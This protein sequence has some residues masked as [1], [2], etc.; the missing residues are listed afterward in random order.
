ML[1]LEDKIKA[2][3][4]KPGVYLLK[5]REGR[6]LYVGKA[7]RL[8]P[9]VRSHFHPG[10]P[11]DPKHASL[12]RQV[13]DFES[14][15]TDS[16]VEALILEANLIKE[17]RPRYNINLKDDKSYPYIR[18]TREQYPR[19]FVT[20][21]IIRDGSRYFGPYTDAGSTRFLMAAVRRI[22]PIRTCAFRI[23]D[24]SIA[25]KKQK[26]CLNYHIGRCGGP[27]EGL[28][29]VDAYGAIVDQIVSFIQGKNTALVGDLTKRMQV[30]SD[31]HRFEEAASVR[32]AIRSIS[33]FQSRQKVV[34]D[35]S[36]DRDIVTLYSE[37]PDTCVVVFMVREGKIIGRNHF[38]IHSATESSDHE[39]MAG[40]LKQFYLRTD[41][42]PPEVLLFPEPAEI[43]EIGEWLTFKRGSGVK[44]AVPQKGK[45]ADLIQMCLKNAGLLLQELRLQKEEQEKIPL[46]VMEL[47]RAL[48]LGTPP[49]H[50]E[51]VDISTLQGTD[52]V[53]SLVVFE[54]GKPRKSEYHRFKLRTLH[55][56]DDF[57]GMA[58]VV[59]RRFSSLLA[60]GK[61]KPDLLLV[62]G[63]K[64]Q[65]S[66]AL[67]AL[68]KLN[69]SDQPVIGLAKRLEEVFVPGFPD[70]Q[71][72]PRSSPAL[73]LLQHIRNEAHRFAVTYHRQRRQKR[74]IHSILDEVPG[75]GGKRRNAL[76]EVFGSVEGIRNASVEDLAKV[77]GMNRK[78]AEAVF[79]ALSRK[80]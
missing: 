17:N 71:N 56:M 4:D 62:D 79:S 33:V 49:L 14:I 46:S 29:S 25:E 68:R 63:G 34:D 40:F 6:I 59:E 60:E 44:L 65:L 66:A 42:I 32:D 19:I 45:K 61:P 8:K 80:P 47:K 55:G 26:V 48:N 28:I 21:K 37:G 2:V 39:R 36:I 67:G 43:R 10:K 51:A 22:F 11:F 15:V 27:C 38:Y 64:G 73:R 1:T 35:L 52:P 76:L 78:V 23:D 7:K 69:I 13:T 58:E 30:L 18:L 77:N 12:M 24:G 57:A 31:Q 53:G 41:F 74:I 3:P 5:D 20:R 16:E 50:I 54:N 70:A 9:R 75:I 72:I